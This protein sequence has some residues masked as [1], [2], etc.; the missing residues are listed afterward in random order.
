MQMVQTPE[1]LIEPVALDA[2]CVS[3][4]RWPQHPLAPGWLD[5]CEI[6]SPS[7]SIFLRI[8]ILTS[9]AHFEPIS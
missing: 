5:L 1:I 9:T 4:D 3:L 2:P 8:L 6:V 7:P